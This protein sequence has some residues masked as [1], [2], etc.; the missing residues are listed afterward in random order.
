MFYLNEL[1]DDGQRVE[2]EVDDSCSVSV[3][4]V[5]EIVLQNY[6]DYKS[7]LKLYRELPKDMCVVEIMSKLGSSERVTL[8]L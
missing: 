4:F 8:N 2:T 7:I 1:Y 6:S 5:D 3:F